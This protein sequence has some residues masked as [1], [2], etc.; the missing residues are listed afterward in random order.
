MWYLFPKEE[1]LKTNIANY[2]PIA[3]ISTIPKIFDNMV[4]NKIS[5]ILTP[6][7]VDS[8]HGF[9]SKKSTTSNLLS[10]SQQVN[11]TLEQGLQFDCCQTD[12]SR[13][14][15]R[16]NINILCSKLESYGIRD[17]L[18]SWLYAYLSDKRQIVKLRN[19]QNNAS[20][21]FSFSQSKPFEALPG[22]IQG[23]HLCIWA[24]L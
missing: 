16:I 1:Y 9:T 11:Y 7:I 22:V 2:R 21:A 5:P 3:K 13:A 12:Y 24:S 6:L 20:H 4:Y 14:F 15:D 10:F 18:L 17:P 19:Q 8:Q 23:G